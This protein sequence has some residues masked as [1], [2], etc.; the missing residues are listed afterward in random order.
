MRTLYDFCG[1]LAQAFLSA[2]A[3]NR[4]ASIQAPAKKNQAI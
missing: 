2:F 1:L 4:R 3:S